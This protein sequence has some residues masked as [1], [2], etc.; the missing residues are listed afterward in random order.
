[1]IVTDPT[2]AK[3]AA[4]RKFCVI[5]DGELATVYVP[6]I[7]LPNLKPVLVSGGDGKALE[8]ATRSEADK[9]ARKVAREW[10]E[11]AE[12]EDGAAMERER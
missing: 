10:R 2:Q 6:R 5:R 4:A 9:H 7:S 12:Q 1:M 8:F 11:E 3:A